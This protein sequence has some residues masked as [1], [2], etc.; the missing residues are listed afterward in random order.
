MRSVR[1][2]GRLRHIRLFI[3]TVAV[4]VAVAVEVPAGE[5]ELDFMD[6]IVMRIA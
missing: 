5:E 1:V 2:A 3:S 6:F 4:A